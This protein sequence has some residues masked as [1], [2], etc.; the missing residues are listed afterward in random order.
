MAQSLVAAANYPRLAP[1][2]VQKKGYDHPWDGEWDRL[3]REKSAFTMTK[4]ILTV[5][6][7]L[8]LLFSFSNLKAQ[9]WVS[10]SDRAEATAK[11]Q[12][13]A[14]L[15]TAKDY[16]DFIARLEKLAYDYQGYFSKHDEYQAKQYQALLQKLILK[17][18]EGKFCGDPERLLDEVDYLRKVLQ[19]QEDEL[20][21]EVG[22][23]KLFRLSRSLQRDL[24]LMLD[25]MHEQILVEME[26]EISREKI[27]EYMEKERHSSREA[28]EIYLQTLV[29]HKELAKQ[30]E[31]AVKAALEINQAVLSEKQLESLKKLE[32]LEKEMENWKLIDLD[33]DIYLVV[34][35]SPPD[36]AEL[37]HPMPN[38]VVPP[39]PKDRTLFIKPGTVS[40]Y[41]EYFDSVRV[42]SP[43][44][45]IFINSETGDL[46]VTGWDKDMVVVKFKVEIAAENE[47][48]AESFAK[49]IQVKLSANEK[50]IYVKAHFPSLSD[51]KRRILSSAFDVRVP[52]GN[53]VISE[54]SFG[55]VKVSNLKK[56]LR[57]NT[58]YCDVRLDEIQGEIEV[59]SKMN[60]LAVLNSSGKMKLQN[61]LGPIQVYRCRGDLDI[62]N[63]Y[64]SVELSECDGPV[65]VRNSGQINI[66][67]H[68][69]EIRVENTN[70]AVELSDVS[71]N[72]IIKNSYKPL[73]VSDIRGSV[74]LQNMSSTIDLS[75]ISGQATVLN[76]YG[77]ITSRYVRGPIE[78]TNEAGTTN[79]S[80]YESLAGPSY[81]V[82]NSGTVQLDLGSDS[83]ILLTVQTEGGNIVGSKGNPI[84]K[85]GYTSSLQMTYGNGSNPLKVTGKATK[86]VIGNDGD[87]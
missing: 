86:V 51:P 52:A 21:H 67:D 9:V 8:F 11:A 29:D 28:R 40:S 45:P 80:I 77:S 69:G 19:E 41:K 15:E 14:E 42:S 6:L 34:P 25:E 27:K 26:T 50:G 12:G 44:V 47:I 53:A 36:P 2:R 74:N 39:V 82:S 66:T 3:V 81:V 54:N 46:R 78:I 83:N 59:V 85:D 49:G 38:V 35:P 64:S 30:I 10:G 63:S 4:R 57:L 65:V 32:L 16:E 20:K 70:G 17:I 31:E 71:G 62:E 13:K 7:A 87:I 73:V 68:S 61:S 43:D 24:E 75:D 33:S 55:T 60:V 18:N 58:S 48:S 56:G 76:K 72:L 22:N 84:R 37:P 1:V 79:L 5:F 23:Y